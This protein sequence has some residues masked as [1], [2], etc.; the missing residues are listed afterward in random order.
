MSS[1]FRRRFSLLAICVALIIFAQEGIVTRAAPTP[2]V[3]INEFM[4]RPNTGGKEWVE[5]FNPAST[6]ID[7]TGWK[8][9]DD[10]PGGAQ[11]VISSGTILPG[12]GFVVITSTLGTGIF[13]DSTP[14]AVQLL[15]SGGTVVDSYA[16]S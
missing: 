13:N 10:T 1:R 11:I 3:L 12:N 2:Q 4:P 8:I 16:Y 7:L 15:D 14:D 9:D 5:L 6:P